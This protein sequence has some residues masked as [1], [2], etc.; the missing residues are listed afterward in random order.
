MGM[1]S[2]VTHAVHNITSGAASAVHNAFSGAG[3]AVQSVVKQEK[4]NLSNINA[5][6]KKPIDKADHVVATNRT[7]QTVARGAG[8][9]GSVFFGPWVSAAVEAKIR[10]A[11][12]KEA[13][14]GTGKQLQA[15]T[16]GA[17]IGYAEGYVASAAYGYA[18]APS[19]GAGSGLTVDKAATT[20]AQLLGAATAA[21]IAFS[22]PKVAPAFGLADGGTVILDAG[23]SGSGAGVPLFAPGAA[24]DQTV[25]NIL[26]LLALAGVAAFAMRA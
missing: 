21:K 5:A 4:R 15:G 14:Q 13:G 10:Q 9:V 16:K 12:A 17:V 3:A 7:V 25:S 24:P 11:K 1:F 8:L 19:S 18:T 20:A 26:P 6:H 23:G 2:G 22:K